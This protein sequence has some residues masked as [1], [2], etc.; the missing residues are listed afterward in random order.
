M[1]HEQLEHQNVASTLE[2]GRFEL[3]NIEN[4]VELQLQLPYAVMQWLDSSIRPLG[5]CNH[6]GIL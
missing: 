1:L 2:N 6:W 5:R 3:E 4:T